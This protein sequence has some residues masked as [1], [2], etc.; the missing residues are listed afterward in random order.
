MCK[1]MGRAPMAQPPGS[2]TRARPH[3]ATHGPSAR[4]EARM[5]F[6]SSY[7]AS[8]PTMAGGSTPAWA[9]PP[10]GEPRA[11]PPRATNGP[12]A[13]LEARMVFTS[14]YGA[15]AQTMAGVSR[16]TVSP[17][18]STLEPIS[19]SSRCM[20]RISRTAGTRRSV[21]G[22]S[23]S[24]AAASAGSA[25]FFDPPTGISPWSAAPPLITNL[26]IQSLGNPSLR[27]GQAPFRILAAHA[28][29]RHHDGHAHASAG[30]RQPLAGPLHGNPGRLRDNA[31]RAVAQLLVLGLNVHHQV[32]VNVT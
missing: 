11:R 10:G 13:R 30:R 28:A 6:T 23:V 12:S 27:R 21:T 32:A 9:P 1:L 7:G 14:S 26:S 24:S 20:V 18:A 8:P 17:S 29:L 4:L 5:V 31:S 25:E 16:R 22:S 3:R 19:T 2:E 15:S